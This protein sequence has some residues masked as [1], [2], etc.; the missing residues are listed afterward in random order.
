MNPGYE[1]ART[2]LSTYNK[3]KHDVAE[4]RYNL[5]PLCCKSCGTK[6][7]RKRGGPK[8]FCTQSCA[9]QYNNRRRVGVLRVCQSCG[10]SLRGAAGKKYCSLSCS[11]V[12]RRANSIAQWLSGQRLPTGETAPSY[13]KAY[14]VQKYGEACQKCGWAERNETTNRIPVQV[15]HI[16]GDYRNNNPNNLHLLCPN[17][18][19]LTPTYGALN[20]GRG[21]TFRRL[22]RNAGISQR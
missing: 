10:K 2:Q 17:C 7:P 15:D 4:Q 9:A 19:S 5:N 8:V 12:G 14:L 22:K 13:I 16:D 3:A 20:K 6:L 1:K 21:R 11:G 18:H